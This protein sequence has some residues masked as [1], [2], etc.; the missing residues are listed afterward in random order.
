[1]PDETKQVHLRALIGAWEGDDP[2]FLGAV[3]SD[4]YAELSGG[5]WDRY[6][7]A[8]RRDGPGTS[9]DREVDV[10]LQVPADLFS[11]PQLSATATT[12]KD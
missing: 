4:L 5:Q 1:M 9:E 6:L 3:E 7:D 12:Q 10:T 2:V 8:W 11:T